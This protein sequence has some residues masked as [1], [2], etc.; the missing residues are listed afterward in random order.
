MAKYQGENYGTV[1]TIELDNEHTAEEAVRA[2]GSIMKA[3]EF[4][5]MSIVNAMYRYADENTPA[6]PGKI[7]FD[8]EEDN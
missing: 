4:H 5:N 2:F 6:E 3:L 7:S 1:I 8:F